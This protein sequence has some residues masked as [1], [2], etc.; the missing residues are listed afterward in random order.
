[1]ALYETLL[2]QQVVRAAIA[3]NVQIYLIGNDLHTLELSSDSA[4][5][6]LT[7]AI[8]LLG[9]AGIWPLPRDQLK[10]ALDLHYGRPLVHSDDLYSPALMFLGL[11]LQSL[12]ENLHTKMNCRF[13]WLETSIVFTVESQKEP[14]TWNLHPGAGTLDNLSTRLYAPFNAADEAPQLAYAKL[15]HA[16]C[17]IQE[18]EWCPIGPVGEGQITI[19]IPGDRHASPTVNRFCIN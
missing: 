1:M 2:S 18:A 17:A 8:S 15:D 11:M 13:L 16:H 9:P 3:N 4:E 14:V 10:C 12:Q 5:S 6:E 19:E 7:L